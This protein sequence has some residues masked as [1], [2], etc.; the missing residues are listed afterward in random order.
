MISS[1]V[2]GQ[3]CEY[4]LP[5]V[6]PRTS[7]RRQSTSPW[8]A[9]S[10]YGAFKILD[11]SAPAPVAS[12]SS[13][14]RRTVICFT[15]SSALPAAAFDKCNRREASKGFLDPLS[16][17]CAVQQQQQKLPMPKPCRGWTARPSQGAR[18]L[19][20]ISGAVKKSSV[21]RCLIAACRHSEA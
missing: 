17:S 8:L 21:R 2:G 15:R 9:P 10:S 19:K 16:G 20:K 11:G 18:H 3:R 12:L 13:T 5:T 6:L 7:R 14:K 4:R 1:S